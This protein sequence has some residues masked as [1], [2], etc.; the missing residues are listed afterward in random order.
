MSM[1]D[2]PAMHILRTYG[3]HGGERQLCQLFEAAKQGFREVF[4]CVYKDRECEARYRKIE[5]LALEK[6]W[7]GAVPPRD[8]LWIEFFCLLAL[9]PILHTALLFQIIKHR[10]RVCVVHGFQAAVVAWP[11]AWLFRDIGFA[12]CHR[13]TKGRWGR[14]RV[15]KILYKPFRC[16]VAISDSVAESLRATT[17]R[18]D[19]VLIMNGVDWQGLRE[20]AQPLE[21]DLRAPFVLTMVGRLTPDK[22]HELVMRSLRSLRHEVANAELWIAGTGEH[23]QELRTVS[24]EMGLEQAV[25]FLGYRKDVVNVLQA[26]DVFVHASKSEGLSNGVLEAMAMGLPSVVVAAPGVSE[27]H[28]VGHTAFVVDRDAEALAARLL[29]LARDPQLRRRMGEKAFER[30]K[31][32]FS[33]E[34][35]RA[36]YASLYRS[37]AGVV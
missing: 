25:R 2:I 5:H 11:M 3:F 30:V 15:F 16:L 19:I 21:R 26:S 29:Q 18:E 36:G 9:L 22:E 6:L 20:Q 10:P 7:P 31:T 8:N 17:T 23:E 4:V 35:N 1:D 34:A 28:E 37:L 27:C 12:Y 32:Q 33:I 24:K 13:S 14:S